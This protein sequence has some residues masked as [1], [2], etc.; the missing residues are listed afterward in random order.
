MKKNEKK[1]QLQYYQYPY[2]VAKS[3]I[4]IYT[5]RLFHYLP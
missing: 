3:L 2:T 5:D 4:K 1:N